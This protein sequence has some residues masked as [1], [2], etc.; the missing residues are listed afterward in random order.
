[1]HSGEARLAAL[2]A[3]HQELEGMLEALH[4]LAR[5]LQAHGADAQA[6]RDATALLD[7]FDERVPSHRA[8]EEREV[9]PLLRRQGGAA[10]RALA[11]R[12]EAE[13]ELLARAWAG[14]RPALAELARGGPWPPDAAALEFDRWRDFTSLATA[15]MLAEDGAA[16]PAAQ[17]LMQLG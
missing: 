8:E 10:G 13:H 16:F 5:H 15:H 4:E 1:M 2:R 11:A 14:C 6:R 9:F 7:F 12:L 3:S 17:G